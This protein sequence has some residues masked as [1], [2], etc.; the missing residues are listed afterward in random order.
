MV[1]FS[2]CHRPRFSCFKISRQ[3]FPYHPQLKIDD[4]II[5]SINQKW[6]QIG[7]PGLL[8]HTRYFWFVVYFAFPLTW[9][10][11]FCIIVRFY[12]FVFHFM[13]NH[14]LMFLCIHHCP[15]SCSR[16]VETFIPI[17]IHPKTSSNLC[18]GS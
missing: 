18:T 8:L 5:L 12:Y 11:Y 1:S 16:G 3:L 2:P 10:S 9:C 15:F 14:P 7:R 4:V 13:R 17:Q 6:G